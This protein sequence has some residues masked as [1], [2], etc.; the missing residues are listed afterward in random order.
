M[1]SI[2]ARYSRV[3]DQIL[4]LAQRCGRPAPRVVAVTKGRPEPEV[5]ALVTAGARDL[6]ESR[7]QELTRRR[8]ALAD[9]APVRWHMIGH[10]QSNKVGPALAAADLIHSV[11]SPDLARRLAERARRDGRPPPHVLAEVNMSG[12]TTKQ[13]LAPEAFPSFMEEIGRLP[14]LH[15]DGLMT[16]APANADEAGARRCF[17]AL[18]GL[19]ESTRARGAPLG[20]ELSMG[21]SRDFPHAIAEGATLLRIGTAFFEDQ[22]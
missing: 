3:M 17:A 22:E 20:P 4:D 2:G 10:L 16:M 12:E 14:G 11:D 18:R 8:T 21:M 15:L 5:R 13:G 1:P 9:L 19:S 7:V 6:G